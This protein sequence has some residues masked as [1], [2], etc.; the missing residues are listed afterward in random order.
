MVLQ[1]LHVVATFAVLSL[2]SNQTWEC[3]TIDEIFKSDVI[4]MILPII[5]FT[6]LQAFFLD[7]LCR[8]AC[9]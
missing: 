4:A 1:F 6:V 8:L 5:E 9:A 7:S 2:D 3:V